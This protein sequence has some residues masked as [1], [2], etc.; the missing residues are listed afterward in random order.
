MLASMVINNFANQN[1]NGAGS[2]SNA[3]FRQ[4]SRKSG[5]SNISKRMRD[6][7]SVFGKSENKGL[8]ARTSAGQSTIGLHPPA[9]KGYLAKVVRLHTEWSV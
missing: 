4:A 8:G 7:T 6:A 1:A 5:L 3:A 2:V 9:R